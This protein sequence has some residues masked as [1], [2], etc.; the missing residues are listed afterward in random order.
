MS[1]LK[2]DV[3][4]LFSWRRTAR[5]SSLVGARVVHFPNR[6]QNGLYDTLMTVKLDPGRVIKTSQKGSRRNLEKSATKG[7]INY[8]EV[9]MRSPKCDD[10]MTLV[11]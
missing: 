8:F 10:F 9:D 3:V 11:E 2:C 1:K 4:T 5:I 6:Y 7:W